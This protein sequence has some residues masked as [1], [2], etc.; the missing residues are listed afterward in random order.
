[1]RSRSRSGWRL[2]WRKKK[3]IYILPWSLVH[4]QDP[5]VNKNFNLYIYVKCT[6]SS[7]IA[8]KRHF[9]SA[10]TLF[11]SQEPFQEA[12]SKYEVPLPE[13]LCF[14]V[15]P[16]LSGLGA[17]AARWWHWRIFPRPSCPCSLL[18][19]L[20]GASCRELNGWV[21][22]GVLP[23]VPRLCNTQLSGLKKERERPLFP[24]NSSEGRD[25]RER[26]LH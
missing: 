3:K 22:S 25:K 15:K 12:V 19:S 26:V 20:A 13:S 23:T 16:V 9:P 18:I 24:G 8:C 5:W 11:L 17:A 7:S 6:E 2:S 14:L 10:G 21:A 4:T 1:M